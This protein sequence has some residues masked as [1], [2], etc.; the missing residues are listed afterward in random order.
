MHASAE[1]RFLRRNDVG[2]VRW[3]LGTARQCEF[4]NVH[5]HISHFTFH[6]SHFIFS[7]ISYFIF[8]ISHL[9]WE[10][11]AAHSLTPLCG[12]QHGDRRVRDDRAIAR[13]GCVRGL[14]EQ[15][16]ERADTRD[17]SIIIYLVIV[18]TGKERNQGNVW[19][20]LQALQHS[21]TSPQSSCLKCP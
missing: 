4:E 12:C 15:M 7:Y 6:I 2:S 3:K 21:R 17:D 16:K 13:C 20:M 11:F 9:T 18:T 14:V 1:Q 19:E 5:I 8:H 10:M